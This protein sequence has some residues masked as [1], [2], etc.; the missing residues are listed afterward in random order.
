MKKMILMLAV[1]LSSV[2]AFAGEENAEIKSEVLDAFKSEFATAKEVKWTANE[3][4][5]KADFIFNNQYIAAYYTPTGEMMG[6]TRNIS[7]LDLPVSLQAKL[8]KEYSKYWI[9]ELFELSNNDGTTYYVT[10]ENADKKIVL[11]STGNNNWN[12]FKKV[13]KA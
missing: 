3:T 8:K 6:V 4:Y 11:K 7:S 9:S 12:V 1:A 5:Y 2:F 13:V 10:L